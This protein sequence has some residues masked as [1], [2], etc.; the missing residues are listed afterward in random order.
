MFTNN[1]VK[2]LEILFSVFLFISVVLQSE[3]LHAHCLLTINLEYL[4]ITILDVNNLENLSRY[5]FCGFQCLRVVTF[6]RNLSKVLS[7]EVTTLF[8]QEQVSII[9]GTPS[10]VVD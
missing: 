7:V 9:V 3:N 8:T 10:V 5:T 1:L 6:D 4:R 2:K